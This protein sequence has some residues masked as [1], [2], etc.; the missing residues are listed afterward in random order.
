MSTSP[1]RKPNEIVNKSLEIHMKTRNNREYLKWGSINILLLSII[2]FDINNKCP[3]VF[4]RLYYIEYAAAFILACTVIYYFSKYF[5]NIFSFVPIRGNEA[6]RELLKFNTDDNSFIVTTPPKK[7]PQVNTTSNT[8]NIS[9]LS[10]HT[11]FNESNTTASPGWLYTSKGQ[12]QPANIT[13]L[14]YSLNSSQNNNSLNASNNS[15]SFSSSFNKFPSNNKSDLIVDEKGLQTYLKE[16][17]EEEK[18]LSTNLDSSSGIGLGTINSLWNSYKLDDISNLLKTSLYQLSPLQS[19]TT[20]KQAIKDET[21][22]YSSGSKDSADISSSDLLKKISSS[23]LSTYVANLRM[24]ISLTILQRL[25]NEISSI[26]QSFK[27]RGFSEIQIGSIGLE[28]LKKT[29]ENQQLVS[30][31]TPTLP[32]LLPFLE[33][34]TNQEYLVQRIKDLAKGSCIADYHWNSGSTFKGLNWDE[35]LPT[36]SAIIFHVFCTYLDS[37]LRPLPAPGGRPFYNRYVII[38][39]KKSAKETLLE[40]KNKAKCAI[41][42]TNP[43]KPKFNFIS[44]DKIHQNAVHDRN[45]LFYVIIQFLIYMKNCH[46][47]S[48]EGINLGKSGIN[49]SCVIED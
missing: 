35:H 18:N 6:Q 48:L 17:M 4:S 39:D 26:D 3:Y 30:S 12:P 20:N 5:Y 9:G 13:A 15:I 25:V 16:A 38:G 24:W 44:D 8:A 22:L 33:L 14:N 49:L 10:W 36:D 32:L 34:T 27:S 29:A 21:H 2:I 19:S 1:S 7:Q 42:C 41:L 37:Q 28:R 47:N 31:C 11:S 43:L 45:N 46:E 40:V 23:Q